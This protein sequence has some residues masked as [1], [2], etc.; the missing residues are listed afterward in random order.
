[1]LIL[2]FAKTYFYEATVSSQVLIVLVEGSLHL[3]MAYLKQCTT[4]LISEQIFVFGL[5]LSVLSIGCVDFFL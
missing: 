2:S 3:S 4:S 5:I 1:M